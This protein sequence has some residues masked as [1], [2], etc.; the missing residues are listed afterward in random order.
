M[1]HE[2]IYWSALTPE[3]QSKLR[4]AIKD[5]AP[6]PVLWLDEWHGSLTRLSYTTEEILDREEVSHV[7]VPR[8]DRRGDVGESDRDSQGPLPVKED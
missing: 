8:I 1:A 4:Q 7:G 5:G 2:V 6:L 3:A